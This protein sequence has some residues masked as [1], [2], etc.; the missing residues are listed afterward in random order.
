VEGN[1]SR[2]ALSFTSHQCSV[3]RNDRCLHVALLVAAFL[4]MLAERLA[5]KATTA[6]CARLFGAGLGCDFEGEAGSL[7]PAEDD[8]RSSIL[9]LNTEG[10]TASKISVLGQL[11][12]ENKAFIIVL[13]ETNC[14]QASDPQL[15]TSW[16]SPEQESRPFHVCSR[17]DGMNTGRSLS[18]TT[19][20]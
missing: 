13:Q 7:L 16:V 8:R 12:S 9:Q 10:S 2:T 19:R 20:D 17:T 3:G 14:R 11:A 4:Q 5:A 6:T 15:L 1:G 18:K